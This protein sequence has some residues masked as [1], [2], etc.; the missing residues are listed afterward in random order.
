[1]ALGIAVSLGMREENIVRRCPVN[2]R[3]CLLLTKPS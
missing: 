1:M 2:T 3:V